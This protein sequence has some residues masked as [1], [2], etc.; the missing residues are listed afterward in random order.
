MDTKV[1]LRKAMWNSG[2]LAIMFI[3]TTAASAASG[4]LL[5]ALIGGLAAYFTV[6]DTITLYNATKS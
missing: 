2:L 4:S 6:K 3:N 1:L 5:F